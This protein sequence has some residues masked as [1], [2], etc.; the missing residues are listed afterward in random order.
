ML[1]KIVRRKRRNSIEEMRI[2]GNLINRQS[3]MLHLLVGTLIRMMI[4]VTMFLLLD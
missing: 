2:K 1:S 4:L 3:I